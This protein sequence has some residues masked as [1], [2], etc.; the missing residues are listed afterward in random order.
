MNKRIPGTLLLIALCFTATGQRTA[1]RPLYAD[2]I[3]DGAADP[4]IVYN[5]KTKQWVMFY[6]NRRANIVDTTVKWVHGTRI[7]MATSKD[8][9]KWNYADTANINYRPDTDYTFWAPH[10]LEHGGIFHMYLTYVPGVFADWNHPRHIVH[11]TSNDLR[12][13][14]YESVLPLANNKV[15]DASVYRM[16]GGTWR[17]WYNNERDGKSIYYADSKD[18]FTWEDKGRAIATRGEGPAVF[19]WKGHYWMIVDAWK[20][21][22]V[23][24]SPD[25]SSWKKQGERI[26]EEG[27][28]GKDDGA[29]GGHCDVVVSGDRA[30]L[31]YFTHPG[32]TAKAPAKKGTAEEK[33][34]VIQVA[35]LK[36]VDGKIVCNRNQ[37]VKVNLK[38]AKRKEESKFL[39][40]KTVRS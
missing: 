14:N 38:K 35:E 10:V 5:Y 16:P 20:G 29:I 37:P 24:Q 36:L 7:G 1:P 22:E 28:T 31:Y 40:R 6:T 15:I 9:A 33:R 2:P 30:F 25:L 3:Y 23:F 18:L 17:M 11:L 19:N 21:L 27:G 12:N 26:L 39:I 34:S 13:W 4:V 8:G 32:R